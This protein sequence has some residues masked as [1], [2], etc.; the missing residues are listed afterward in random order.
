MVVL[1]QAIKFSPREKLYSL[2]NQVIKMILNG[3]WN[4]V[5]RTKRRCA[6]GCRKDKVE[7][8]YFS[9]DSTWND[10]ETNMKGKLD[11][12][13]VVVGSGCENLIPQN[14]SDEREK[15]KFD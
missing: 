9:L 7:P 5:N 3:C 14:I 1:A 6:T 4:C 12:V 15:V 11:K 13:G 10:V 2:V 8:F